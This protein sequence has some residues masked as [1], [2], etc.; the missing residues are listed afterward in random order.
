MVVAGV[1]VEHH[2]LVEAVQKYFVDIKPL[3]ETESDLLINR[4]NLSC[5]LSIAQYTGGMV[6]VS[7]HVF[8]FYFYYSMLMTLMRNFDCK[9]FFFIGRM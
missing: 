8:V 2:R 9:C 7:S 6:Q 1:G 3:W 5:D 4:R